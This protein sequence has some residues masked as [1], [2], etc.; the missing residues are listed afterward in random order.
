LHPAFFLYVSRIEHPGKNHVRLIDAF[1]LFKEQTGLSHRLVLI[2]AD[3]SGAERVHRRAGESLFAQDI[4][5]RGLVSEGELVG[6]YRTAEARF[7]R[8]FARA[9]AYRCSKPWRVEHPLPVRI[10]PQC[11][12]SPAGRLNYLPPPIRARSPK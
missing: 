5:F 4:V 9:S 6:A 1:D 2:G 12:R 7:F 8:R 11:L 10:P 3:W